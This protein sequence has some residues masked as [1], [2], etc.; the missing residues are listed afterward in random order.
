MRKFLIK[1][2]KYK[3]RATANFGLEAVLKRE[4]QN[5]GFTDLEVFDRKIEFYG[6]AKD[7]ALCNIWLRTAERVFII[8]DEFPAETFDELFEKTKALPW[9]DILPKNAKF[10]VQG[11]TYK[12]KLFSISDSQSIVKKAIVESLRDTYKTDW[13]EE[14]GDNYQLEI[15]I[16]KDIACITLDTSGQGLHK[17]GYRDRA[18][19]A[20]LKETMASALVQLSYWNPDRLLVDPFC[21]SGTIAIEAAMLGKNIA[22]GLDRDFDAMAWDIIGKDLFKEVRQDAMGQVKMDVELNI[23]GT[24][25]DKWGIDRSISNRDNL[26]LTDDDIRFEI[27]DA[28]SFYTREDYGVLITNPPYGDR[29]GTEEEIRS[30]Y[31][32]FGKQV[33]GLDTWS[34][35]VLTSMESFEKDFGRQADRKRKLYNGKLKVDYYQFYGPRPPVK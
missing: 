9:A 33:R 24:D 4:L 8:L 29:M 34:F 30:L 3:I 1:D 27:K 13:F 6:T 32:D 15:E 16:I 21:G 26:G 2:G 25:I 17:R 18:G 22:P 35:Y 20:P 12:S 23:L 14:D 10:P 19:D 11:R 31:K 7:V 28:R 5:L